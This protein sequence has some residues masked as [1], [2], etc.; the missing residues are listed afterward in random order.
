MKALLKKKTR[1]GTFYIMQSKDGYFHPVFDNESLGSYSSI[2]QA[3]DDISHDATFSVLHPVTSNLVD[4][5]ELGL[6]E[7]PS[8]WEHA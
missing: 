1:I 7:D 3:V 6:P 8:E 2:I 5:S 4:T